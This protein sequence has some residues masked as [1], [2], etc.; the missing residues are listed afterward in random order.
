[1]KPIGNFAGMLLGLAAGDALGATLEF[2]PRRP[3]DNLHTEMTGGGVFRLAPGQWT[4]DTA[5][6]VALGRSLLEEQAFRPLHEWAEWYRH[7]KHSCTGTC[8]DIGTATRSA[9]QAFLQDPS[10]VPEIPP[11]AL[12][13]G[14]L[15]RLAPAVLFASD[16]EEAGSLAYEQSVLTHGEDAAQAT[17]WFGRLL[18]RTATS[19]LDTSVFPAG[20]AERKREE[21]SASGF[22][23]HTL[24]A[25]LWA[26]AATTNFEGAIVQ[27]VNLGGDADSVGAVA[28]QLAGAVYGEAGIPERWLAPLAWRDELRDMA[29]ALAAASGKE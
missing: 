16:E 20:I 2:G 13:N 18:F 25:A 19:G 6:A 11:S 10:A 29:G 12:G 28:G 5:M 27:A 7:G 15:M 22:Y 23:K 1:M 8:F 3:L 4:D 9:L 21:V 26:V 14:S 17:A 24:E